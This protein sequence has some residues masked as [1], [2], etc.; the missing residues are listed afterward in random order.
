MIIGIDPGQK[1]AFV[2]IDA[3]THKIKAIGRSV[4][5]ADL[6][7]FLSFLDPEHVILEK[8]QSMPRQSVKSTFTYAQG[9]GELIGV[10]TCLRIPYTL[11]RPAIWTA[12]L[13]IGTSDGEPKARSAEAFCRLFPESI[14][15][16]RTPKGK[17]HDGVVDAALI[18]LYGARHILRTDS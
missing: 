18:A 9:Y 5:A 6:H 13:H 15:S 1:G 3:S 14:V 4:T 7:E 12:K 11:I 10:L 17:L 2:A 16:I 8:A